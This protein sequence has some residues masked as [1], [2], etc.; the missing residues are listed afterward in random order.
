MEIKLNSGTWEIDTSKPLGK[1]GGFGEVFLGGGSNGPAAI[2]RLKLTA[3]QA[4]HREMDVG[5]ELAGK[6]YEHVVPILDSG[7][8]ADSDRYYLVMPVCERSLQDEIDGSPVEVAEGLKITLQ[9]L[10]GLEEVSQ[11]VH[12]DLKP[13]NILFHEGKWK[14]AD[15]GIAKFVED[16]TSLETLRTSL[17]PSYAAPE[18]WSLQ[19][20]TAATDIYALGCIVHALVSG[21][22]P[23]KGDVD[24]LREQHLSKSPPS[25]ESLPPGVRSIVSVMLRKSDSTRPSRSRCIEVFTKSIAV[26][27]SEAPKARS[28][29]Q[30]AV[31]SIATAQAAEE[32]KRSGERD[33]ASR[34][35]AIFEEAVTDLQGIKG[36]LFGEIYEQG[37]DVIGKAPSM[38]LPLVTIGNAVLRFD[39]GFSATRGIQYSDPSG[40]GDGGWGVHRKNSKW[41]IVAYT[42]ISLE[43][44][45]S[46]IPCSRSASLIYAK[47][48]E[49]GDYRWYELSFF[50]LGATYSKQAPY[51]LDYPWEI[52]T[53]L[54][55]T[56]DIHQKAQE[57]IPIDGECEDAFIDY[58]LDLVSQAATGRMSRPSQLPIRR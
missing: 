6:T 30:E 57:P 29:L 52:D 1:E 25:L 19:R 31:S 2:K 18:Q 4:A 8:D 40:G 12:R 17:T 41:D 11:I 20:P 28:R 44:K 35:R 46:T 34:R 37:K 50:Y 45:N 10:R 5:A 55:P 42:Q 7:L 51:A 53:V 54:S 48:H 43:Q 26:E 22:P 16:S 13:S 56:M 24:A 33:R 23:F 15:F 39:T 47:S 38:N 14:L 32:A 58:W 49:G 21:H 3:G 36:R 27:A 9:I